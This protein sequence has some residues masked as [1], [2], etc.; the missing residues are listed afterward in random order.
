VGELR[1]HTSSV[2]ALALDEATNQVMGLGKGEGGL[3]P[4]L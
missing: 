1:G 4:C 3:Q 2:T